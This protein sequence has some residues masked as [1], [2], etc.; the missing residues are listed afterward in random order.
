VVPCS[1]GLRHIQLLLLVLL[2]MLLA[3][4]SCE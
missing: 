2:L 3:H 4:G 1:G